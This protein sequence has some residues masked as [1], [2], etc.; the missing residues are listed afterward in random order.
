MASL[1]FKSAKDISKTRPFR[2]SAAISIH[3]NSQQPDTPKIAQSAKA[4]NSLTL[5]GRLVGGGESWHLRVKDSW[6]VNVVPLL[7]H[8]WVTTTKM[9][10]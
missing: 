5:T 4:K 3:S 9:A 6:N 2:L 10:R 8:E 1:G 7:S